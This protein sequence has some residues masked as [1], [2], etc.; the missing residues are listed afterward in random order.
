MRKRLWVIRALPLFFVLVAPSAL[1]A[2]GTVYYFSQQIGNSS[3]EG[4]ITTDGAM[5]NLSLQ[6]LNSFSFGV[7]QATSTGSGG[8]GGTAK[9]PGNTVTTMISGLNFTDIISTSFGVTQATSTGTGGAGGSAKQPGNTVTTVLS[10]QDF[11]A[12]PSA[13]LFN[14]S[15]KDDGYLAFEVVLPTG[16]VE[17]LCWGNGAWPCSSNDPQGIAISNILGDGVYSF[18]GESGTQV[19]AFTTP[20]PEPTTTTLLLAGLFLLQIPAF[21]KRMRRCDTPVS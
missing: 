1:L 11:T 2:D 17:Y 19:I 15:G 10:G 5:G 9:Q 21:R 16:A 14:F 6:D 18:V 12:T 8:A 3:I 7:T 13:L 20:A 4:T